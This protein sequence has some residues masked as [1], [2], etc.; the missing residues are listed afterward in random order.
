M[1]RFFVA[2]KVGNAPRTRLRILDVRIDERLRK[3]MTESIDDTYEAIPISEHSPN[4]PTYPAVIPLND[5]MC[6]R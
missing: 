1:S 3:Q 6:R 5:S 4:T 2:K